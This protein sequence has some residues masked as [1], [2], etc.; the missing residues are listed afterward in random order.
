MPPATHTHTHTPPAVPARPRPAGLAAGRVT[1]ADVAAL[2]R[3]NAAGA[4]DGP[5]VARSRALLDASVDAQVAA[6]LLTPAQGGAILG[7]F[8]AAVAPRA[9]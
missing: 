2:R 4:P 5:A 7:R 3:R 8:D 6:G 1:R 9:A